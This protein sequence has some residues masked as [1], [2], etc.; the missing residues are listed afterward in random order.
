M[1]SKL[2][3]YVAELVG[4]FVLVYVA[5]AA[6]CASRLQL[7]SGPRVD[8]WAVALAQGCAYAVLLAATWNVSTYLLV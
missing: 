2:R 8:L 1:E 5:A 6:V 3:S 7:E 4:T